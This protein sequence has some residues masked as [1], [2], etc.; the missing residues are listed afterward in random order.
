MS[1]K[2]NC[3]ERSTD[4]PLED[5]F[6]QREDK[7]THFQNGYTQ[8]FKCDTH[9]LKRKLRR[10]RTSYVKHSQHLG[11]AWTW[12]LSDIKMPTTTSSSCRLQPAASV[13]PGS[14]GGWLQQ[15]GSCHLHGK[16]GLSPQLPASNQPSPSH[17]RYSG[18]EPAGTRV[19]FFLFF[20]LSC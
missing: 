13:G 1:S 12:W 16:L 11:W 9:G 19:C 17:C 6:V 10:K 2:S 8:R 5:R 4:K 3:L 14:Q 7:G 15:W 18:N 20:S